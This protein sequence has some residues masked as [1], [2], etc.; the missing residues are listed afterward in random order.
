MSNLPECRSFAF[1]ACSVLAYFFLYFGGYFFF[2][3]NGV[4]AKYN[5]WRVMESNNLAIQKQKH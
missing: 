2:F 5:G 3:F 1:H 4:T